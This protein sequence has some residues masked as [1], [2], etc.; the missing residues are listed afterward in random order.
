MEKTK[1]KWRT[2][3]AVTDAESLLE[4]YYNQ[5]LKWGSVLTRG[6]MGMAQDIVHDLCLHFTL[7]KPD[8]SQ[9][10]N[11]DGY[12]YTCLRH[13]Y[14]SALARAS[15]EALQFVSVA[16]F[17]SIHF[18][19]SVNSSDALLQRQNDLRRICSY[20]VWRKQA[21]KSASYLILLFF[22]GY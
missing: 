17:D 9:V 22:H 19:L 21:S 8:L 1:S 11:M 2:S 7:A 18:A 5:L 14:L 16:E 6:D 20:T 4:R 10:A 12:L 15:R 13:I 3:R